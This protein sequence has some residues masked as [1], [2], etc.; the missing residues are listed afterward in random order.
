MKKS[1]ELKNDIES[2]RNEINDLNEKKEDLEN[3]FSRMKETVNFDDPESKA[4]I[5]SVKFELDLIREIIEEKL[6]GMKVLSDDLDTATAKED[7]QNTI[8]QLMGYAEQAE[9]LQADFKEQLQELDEIISQRIPEIFKI[10]NHW[11][12]IATKFANLA[13]QS[14]AGRGLKQSTSY[15]LN[16]NGRANEINSDKLLDEL[17]QAGANLS[18]VLSDSVL[19]SQNF[20]HLRPSKTLQL[21]F[22]ENVFNMLN[23]S[24]IVD[25]NSSMEKEKAETA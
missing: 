19:S 11:K 22:R 20:N 17:E 7:R 21:N 3:T 24:N 8:R 13:D 6:K 25:L 16:R 23:Q 9:L 15:T 18:A 5:S 10:R 2:L 14:G 12:K 4:D 1:K